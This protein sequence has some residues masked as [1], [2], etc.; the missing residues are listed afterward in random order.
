MRVMEEVFCSPIVQFGKLKSFFIL[1]DRL[2]LPLE[3]VLNE[4]RE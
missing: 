1:H 3:G 4:L 2:P